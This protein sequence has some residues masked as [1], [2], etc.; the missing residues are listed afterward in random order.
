M[1]EI[2]RIDKEWSTPN[3][4]GKWIAHQTKQCSCAREG[5]DLTAW[6]GEKQ[7][8]DKQRECQQTNVPGIST[9]T[10]TS[11]RVRACG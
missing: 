2:K 9:S 1:K 5:L 7:K 6:Y 10:S 8:N 4:G 11:V 3:Q